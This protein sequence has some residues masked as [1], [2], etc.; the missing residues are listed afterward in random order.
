MNS[1][2]CLISTLQSASNPNALASLGTHHPQAQGAVLRAVP[3]LSVPFGLRQLQRGAR[4]IPRSLARAEQQLV[5]GSP[6]ALTTQP[7]SRLIF[8]A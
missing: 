7:F 3:G 5:L 6:H 8:Q 2:I 1:L 4:S